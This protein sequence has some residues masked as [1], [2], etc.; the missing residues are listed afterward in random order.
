MLDSKG[1]DEKLMTSPDVTV[2]ENAYDWSRDGKWILA[3]SNRDSSHYRLCLFPVSGAPQAENG[4]RVVA[5]HPEQS[6][7]QGRFSPDDRWILFNA[8]T[9]DEPVSVIYVIPSAGGPWTP[10]TDESYWADKGRWSP[11]GRTIYFISNRLTGFFNVW[12]MKF[13]AATGKPA[14][15]PFRVTNLESP[16]R[17]ILP[18]VGSLEMAVSAERLILPI[19]EVRG[20]IWVLE[21][22]DR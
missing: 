5:E 2:N 22:V 4:M 15:E 3:S 12:G 11:D 20:N 6:L 1:G 14:G 7:W 9:M 16:G 8:T 17:M 10:V 21:N 19:R 18:L 13:D